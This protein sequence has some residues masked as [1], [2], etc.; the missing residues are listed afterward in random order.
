[1]QFDGKT[2]LVVG[3][4]QDDFRFIQ[5]A[6]VLLALALPEQG[7]ANGIAGLSVI[8]RLADGVTPL[9]TEAELQALASEMPTR[10][11]FLGSGIVRVL[12]PATSRRTRQPAPTHDCTE[13]GVIEEFTE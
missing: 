5:S 6:D 4:L 13:N 1:M 3:V 2:Y 11:G 8:G 7:G 9:Q 12:L 10:Y